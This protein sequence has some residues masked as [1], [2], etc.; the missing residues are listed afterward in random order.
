MLLLL[1]TRLKFPSSILISICFIGHIV[2]SGES[3]SLRCFEHQV[4]TFKFGSSMG[5]QGSAQIGHFHPDVHSSV[6][7]HSE[8]SMGF[9]KRDTVSCRVSKC[10]LYK[11]R[12]KLPKDYYI[13]LLDLCH[14]LDIQRDDNVARGSVGKQTNPS[15][16]L[17]ICPSICPIIFAPFRRFIK[18]FFLSC[19][20]GW[21]LHYCS[22]PNGWLAFFYQCPAQCP[23]ALFR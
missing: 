8:N 13:F 6:G 11:S 7:F 14:F 23:P 15:V 10:L 22:C 21:L 20:F 1:E 12:Q 16:C 19:D 5:G 9:E 4:I 2:V 18:L 17:S 3:R